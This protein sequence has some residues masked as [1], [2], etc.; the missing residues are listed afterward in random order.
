MD[1][2]DSQS[3]GSAHDSAIESIKHYARI[4]HRRAQS[5]DAS[6]VEKLRVLRELRELATAQISSTI[7]RRQCLTASAVR[8]GFLSWD[9]VRQVLGGETDDFGTLL[10]PS[11][12][13]GHTNIW[14]ANYDEARDIRAEHGGYLLAYRR[15]FLI[16]DR[17]YVDSLGLDPDDPD[18]AA[19]ARDWVQPPD[20]AARSRLYEKLVHNA[21]VRDALS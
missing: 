21:L 6:A 5:G 13:Y 3:G 11:S 18:W 16:V 7:Q 8:L 15:Q 4:L 1:S 14:S 12:C 20:R 2:R 10:Y 19:I 17:A 9:H